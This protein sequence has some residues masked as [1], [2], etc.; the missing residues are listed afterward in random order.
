MEEDIAEA[1][2][3][4][5]EIKNK[6]RYWNRVLLIFGSMFILILLL[7]VSLTPNLVEKIS[8]FTDNLQGI[9][10][11]DNVYNYDPITKTADIR[12]S[13]LAIPFLE[14]DE[15]ATAQLKSSDY[16]WVEPNSDNP[17]AEIR[18]NNSEDNYKNFFNE[19]EFYNL[20]KGG[21]QETKSIR[22]KYKE[23]L[24]KQTIDSKEW[25][26]DGL[27]NKSFYCYDKPI[28]IEIDKWGDWKDMGERL[29]GLPA[30][31][32]MVGLFTDIKSGDYYEWIPTFGGVRITEWAA[33]VGATRF[34]FYN[35]GKD[36][37]SGIKGPIVAAGANTSEAQVFRVGTN[38]TNTTFNLVGVRIMVWSDGIDGSA[39]SVALVA[40]NGTTCDPTDQLSVNYSVNSTGMATG[41]YYNITL[42]TVSLSQGESYC[43]WA[44]TTST[45]GSYEWGADASSP[46]YQG[47]HQ[48]YCPDFGVTECT[49]LTTRDLMF[50][51]YGTSPA[52]LTMDFPTNTTYTYQNLSLNVSADAT[53]DTWYWTNDSGANNRTFTPNTSIFW[54]FGQHVLD[55]WGNTTANEWGNISVTFAVSEDIWAWKY[56]NSTYNTSTEDYA[57]NLTFGTTPTN[58]NFYYNGTK[59]GA[60]V[61][62]IAGNNYT[63]N[64]TLTLNET[65]GKNF[66]FSY[67]FGTTN[68][69]SSTKNQ[70]VEALTFQLCNATFNVSYLNFTFKDED[71]LNPIN[72]SIDSSTWYTWMGSDQSIN[73]SYSYSQTIQKDSYAF[74]FSPSQLTINYDLGMEYNSIGY[75]QRDYFGTGTLTNTTTDKILYLLSSSDGIYV[76]YQ[77]ISGAYSPLSNTYVNATRDIG[78]SEEFVGS[79]YTGDDGAVTFWLNPD[80][81][82]TL[83]FE[84]SGY[85]TKILTHT[86]TESDYTITLSQTTSANVT[87]YNRGISYTIEPLN[88]TLRN[89]TTYTFNF[90]IVSSYWDLDQYGF[91]LTNS[92]GAALGSASGSTAGGG[93]ATKNLNTANH[94]NIIMEYYWYTNSTYSNG[95]TSW[96]VTYTAD[97]GF[98]LLRFFK[99]LKTYTDDEMFGLNMWS[100]TLIIFLLIFGMVGVMS[101]WS[102]IYSP[103]AILIE[104]LALVAF[105]DVG[106]GMIPAP[107]PKM[108]LP[109]F[110]TIFVGI[111]LIG[112]LLLEW[113]T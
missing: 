100:R 86:P 76:T 67:D 78:G 22:Y 84:K 99:D 43:I 36:T 17:F 24:G 15:V 88:D 37:Q 89:E 103:A 68:R 4:E 33:F 49:L 5:E 14:L 57:I 10:E 53:I 29:E 102:G 111:I 19:V 93:T 56:E 79:G 101:Y 39:L 64:R 40:S 51:V 41:K 65:G 25:T 13:V 98:S 80:Y 63:I 55:V 30:E 20:N 77:V 87:D 82:H 58:A 108:P 26:C 7:L 11:Y 46:T 70:S 62:N 92:T 66:F 107:F 97:E 96:Y 8:S 106:L 45:T 74:C 9:T 94:T 105:F 91:Y 59:Y 61:T 113:K 85:A 69:N 28:Q 90:T 104:L 110:P 23:Y 75:V 95:T 34:E 42:P 27:E 73:N 60:S 109:N 3:T 48:Q 112:Y 44:N 6:N 16:V 12:N 71:D 72:A 1:T 32:I 83:T 52:T 54:G 31:D 38:G 81:T 35:D 47:G 21:E 2:L 50:E 18:V